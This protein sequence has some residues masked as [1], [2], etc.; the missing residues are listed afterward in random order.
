M[1][2]WIANWTAASGR[3]AIGKA[4]AAGFDLIEISLPGDLDLGM[5]IQELKADLAEAGIDVRFSLILPQELHM[6]F[7]PEK[8]LVHL[9]KAIDLVKEAGG[10]SLVGVLYTAIG[11]FT[12]AP[13]TDSERN[14]VIAVL[15]D[16]CSYAAEGGIWLA[17]EPINRYE[18][19]VLNGAEQTLD[20]I[21]EVD[22][23]NLRLMLDSFHMNI[24][25]SNYYE[26]VIKAA[27]KL[28]Y[29][30][31]A[32]SDRGMP[33][34]DNV[35]WDELFKGLAEIKYSG[36]LVLENFS[37]E[38]EALRGPTSL[39]RTSKYGA[40]DLARG[41]LHFIKEKAYQYGLY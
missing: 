11:V 17:L 3:Y 39:W 5:D 15:T 20:L 7:Y 40:D 18:S 33:G 4:A 12:G 37:S 14:T 22:K 34:L 38:V 9:K 13:C 10:S 21:K 8:A 2:S 36:A 31:I 27:D 32:S 19:Y 41:G 25:E 29:L 30:H 26:P 28:N 24:E 1:V 35:N 16:A 6:P 23:D